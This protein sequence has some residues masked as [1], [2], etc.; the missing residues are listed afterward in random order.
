LL[1]YK[2]KNFKSLGNKEELV[3]YFINIVD[4]YKNNIDIN[5]P[6]NST[7]IEIENILISKI[8]NIFNL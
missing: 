6:E 5:I 1:L 2:I 8:F 3:N 7:I 4:K